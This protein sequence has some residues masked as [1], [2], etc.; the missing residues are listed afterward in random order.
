VIF[1]R[2]WTW[3]FKILLSAPRST[4][5]SLDP[6]KARLIIKCI[7]VCWSRARITWSTLMRT[8]LPWTKYAQSSNGCGRTISIGEG[9]W[10][11]LRAI[12]FATNPSW[13][14][15]WVMNIT[16]KLLQNELTGHGVWAQW[17]LLT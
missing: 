5:I 6:Q 13:T 2:S 17:M 8:L 12:V 9:K 4:C 11:M 3:D 16:K 15:F 10:R 1:K 14:D 7:K